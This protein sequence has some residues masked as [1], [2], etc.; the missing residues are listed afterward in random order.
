M[1]VKLI[2]KIGWKKL[3][4]GTLMLVNL[5][6]IND[7]NLSIISRLGYQVCSGIAIYAIG[8]IILRDEWFIGLINRLIQN[9]M[10]KIK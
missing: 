8:L 3:L 2:L 9:L 1:T 7:I 5:L 10:R 4:S 6:V